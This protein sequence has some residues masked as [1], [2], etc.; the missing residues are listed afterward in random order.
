VLYLAFA[1]PLFTLGALGNLIYSNSAIRGSVYF[2][3][4]LSMGIFSLAIAAAGFPFGLGLWRAKPRAHSNALSY[5]IIAPIVS[6]GFR[7]WTAPGAYLTPV[8]NADDIG[9]IIRT[10]LPSIIWSTYLMCSR[11]V[12]VTFGGAPALFP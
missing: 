6:L 10:V 4:L 2:P 3:F 11:R 7:Y 1:N 12:R 9:V 5:F 8:F